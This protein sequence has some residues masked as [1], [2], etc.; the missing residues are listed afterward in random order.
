[1]QDVQVF[2]GAYSS[3]DLRLPTLYFSY[4]IA[5]FFRTYETGTHFSAILLL[6]KNNC[7]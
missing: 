1:M 6:K 2:I 5:N 7:V 4:I 3:N